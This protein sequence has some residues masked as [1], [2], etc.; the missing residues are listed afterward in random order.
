MNNPMLRITSSNLKHVGALTSKPYAYTAR[1]WELENIDSVDFHDAFGSNIQVSVR[2]SEILRV[3]PKVNENLNEEWITDKIRYSYDGIKT[4]R[5]TEPLIKEDGKFKTITWEKAFNIL[6]DKYIN[7]YQ[8]NGVLGNIT[9]AETAV[10]FKEFITKVGNGFLLTRNSLLNTDSDMRENYLLNLLPNNL[11]KIQVCLIIGCNLRLEAPILNLK[12]RRNVLNNNLKI[13]I[14]GYNADLTY[15][16]IFV[17]NTTKILIS[18]CRGK[19]PLSKILNN[20]K[21]PQIFVGFSLLELVSINIVT[22]IKKYVKDIKINFINQFSTNTIS[23]EYNI[24]QKKVIKSNKRILY[25]LNNDDIIINKKESDFIVYQGHHGS[26]ISASADLILPGSTLLEK[27]GTL[28]NMQGLHQQIN[29]CTK[30]PILARNDWKILEALMSFLG[31]KTNYNNIENIR[32]YLHT[33]VPIRNLDNTLTILNKNTRESVKYKYI[34]SN[35]H[36]FYL[37]DII[38]K[39]SNTLALAST[40]FS[41]HNNNFIK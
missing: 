13:Y 38:S 23:L 9:D 18:I 16:A 40:R 39:N 3:L 17:G 20:V 32:K 10:I 24:N 31:F 30:P 5:L 12:I 28:V 35:M 33:L 14:L 6:K 19:H 25:I 8:F 15:P 7:K 37:T 1:P 21:N 34:N 11:N 41:A 4:Q 29:F 27:N 22:Y 2:G 26:Q 36:N